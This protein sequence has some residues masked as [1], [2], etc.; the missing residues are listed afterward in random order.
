MKKF[1]HSCKQL[2]LL[3]ATAL[4]ASTGAFAAKF[5]VDGINYTTSKTNATVAR[6][7]ITKASGDTPA[8]TAFYTGNVVIPE[9]V[10]Y[11]GVTYTVVATAANA[12]VDC[13]ELTSVT[14]PATCVTIGRNSFKGC[15]SLTNDPVPSTAV[16]LGNGYL[17]GC[18]SITEVTVPSGVTAT[19]AAQQYDGCTSLKK[20]TF[21]E[22]TEPLQLSL[23][24]FTSG[25][26][27]TSPIEEL[28][29][30]RPINSSNYDSNAQPFHG[31]TS[32]KT[33]TL[34]GGLASIDATMFQGATALTTVNFLDGNV[35]ASL[36]ADAF[37]GCSSLQS[38]V[39]PEAITSIPARAF[40]ACTA[41]SSIGMSD[42]VTSIEM[43]AFYNTALT[44]FSFPSALTSI[45]QSAFQNSKLAGEL[46]LPGALTYIGSQA[47][48]GTSVTGIAIPATVTS[49]GSAAFAPIATLAG[50]TSASENFVVTDS[51]VLTS[52]DGTRVLVAAHQA[53]GLSGAL[54][55]PN[56]TTIDNYG[57]A[58]VPFTSV[59]MPALE[60]IGNYGF[61]Y[62]SL[63]DFTVAQGVSVGANAFNGSA[64]KTLAFEEGVNEIP[65]GIAA[66]CASLETVTMPA[67]ITNIMK[68]AF[69]G[70]TALKHMELPA[71]V[72]YMEPGAV[73]ATIESLRVLN[74]STPA[75]A[76]NVFNADQS[77]VECKVAPKSVDTYKATAQWQY[78]NIVADPTI[79]NTA[80]DLGCP[81]G[82]YFATTDGKLMYK[83]EE[84]NVVDTKFNA[85]SHALALQSYKNRI[86]VAVAGERFTYENPAYPTGDG[87][88]FYVNNT[89]GIFYR[90]TVLNNVGYT[91]SEDPFSM[92]IDSTTNKIY[93]SDRN[94][95]VHMLDADTTGLYGSQPFLVNN[96]WLPY[97]NDQ[98]SWGSITGGFQRDS[99]GIYWMTKKF[100]GLGLFRFTDGDI[101]PDGGAGHT[102][103]YKVLFKDDAIKTAYLDEKNGYYYMMVAADNHSGK[104]PGLYRIA[105]SKL[106]D[107]TGADVDGNDQ[108]TIANC[109]LIDDA[110]FRVEGSV[111]SYELA[112]MAQINGD[113]ENIYWS[114][115]SPGA[116]GESLP[117]SV[118]YDENNPL[119]KSGIKTIKATGTPVVTY[120]VE[121]VEAYGVCGAT[122]VAPEQP[123]EILPTSIE[124]NYVEYTVENPGDMVQLVATVLPEEA[125]NKEVA[126]SSDNEQVAIVD[127]NGLVTTMV[128]YGA[129]ALNEGVPTGEQVAN[130]TATAVADENV[131]AVCAITVNYI[132]GVTTI[133]NTKVVKSVSYYN[134][135]GAQSATASKGVNI[136]VTTYSD[137][138]Q[139]VTK[140]VK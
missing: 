118:A 11:D 121:D 50:I 52:A 82:L 136:M 60:T 54:E 95:G 90:V 34:G 123:E 80:A 87:E 129:P 58:Y 110:P 124:L 92:S 65:Q 107:E 78:L 28:T 14:L 119:H 99:H 115:N 126:W 40:S 36:G 97:Y 49:I 44:S 18:T 106:Q 5:T 8:D 20:L 134:A 140:V 122:Y 23:A 93:I 51:K 13:R 39:L 16:S 91:P 12:F 96:S 19:M 86:Y 132:T 3:S 26:S 22:S 25:S 138:S 117:N 71:T 48:A 69:T 102:Q 55:L 38:I 6:Y 139:E 68:D 1:R 27:H 67:T 109:E 113:G 131:K 98:I 17:Q 77:N 37:S 7:T 24:A 70:C 83:D 72:N 21:A 89:N 10:E 128:L 15:V 56:A 130:I 103:H 45:G 94:V 120:A 35:I 31:M 85:G 127:D 2:M 133:G 66:N 84:G 101:Y 59:N 53:A 29:I 112:T 116:D 108:L 64:L 100:N 61:A 9:T 46:N 4:M 81:T 111:A 88:L 105:L 41:L 114:Y 73:P 47:F 125:D 57:L 30:L 135:A 79:S 74:T 63:E 62:S 32:L 33:L 104:A 42:N 76:A 137:G 43:N 75:L